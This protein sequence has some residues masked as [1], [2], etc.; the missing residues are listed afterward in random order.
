MRRLHQGLVLL[1]CI[2]VPAAAAPVITPATNVPLSSSTSVFDVNAHPMNVCGLGAGTIL[3]P[4]GIDVRDLF[5]GAYSY[6]E[7]RNVIFADRNR[8]F[9]NSVVV[10]LDAPVRLSS[11]ELFLA[12]DAS[13]GSRSASEFR[14]YAGTTL[15]DD[16]SILDAT[17]NQTYSG[18]Y[19]NT[20]IEIRDTLPAGAPL[21]DRYV[22]QFVQ[23]QNLPFGGVRA[24]EFEALAAPSVPGDVNGDG[25]V[26]FTDL[27]T[28][29]QHYGQ[30][31]NQTSSDGD[32]NGDGAVGFD[33]LLVLA[34]HYGVGAAAAAAVPEPSAGMALGFLGVALLCRGSRRQRRH[35]AGAVHR[36]S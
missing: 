21:S 1:I 5:G 22:L 10:V 26:D 9:T 35:P 34:Q 8:G 16:V 4:N 28:L 15:L 20:G 32:F 25:R 31:S 19:G 3:N 23:N 18:V 36:R 29:A 12:D 14:L 6:T 33:D 24:Q 13:T 11:Y 27:L 2:S 17:G 30:S 7:P